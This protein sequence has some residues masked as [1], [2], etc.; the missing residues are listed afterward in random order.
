MR[1]NGMSNELVCISEARRTL[2]P[3]KNGREPSPATAWRWWNIGI[4]GVKLE[5][6]FVGNTPFTSQEMIHEFFQRVT[7]ARTAK[8]D[9]RDNSV[10]DDELADAG[11]N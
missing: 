11:L 7:A 6:V 10:S 9:A 8:R 2:I 3:K 4:Q 1:Q 5:V